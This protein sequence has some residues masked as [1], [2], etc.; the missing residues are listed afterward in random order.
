SRVDRGA[1]RGNTVSRGAPAGGQR[2]HAPCRPLR[3]RRAA[4]DAPLPER[5][6]RP[7]R[8][9]GATSRFHGGRLARAAHTA[10]PAPPPARDCPASLELPLRQRMLEVVAVNLVEN[11]I[12]YAGEGSTF[13][14]SVAK[15]DGRCALTAV[16]D[17]AGVQEAE[18]P[19]L[20]ERFY[21]ADRARAS[22]S[23]GLGLAIVKHIVG[24]AGGSVEAANAPGGGLAVRCFFP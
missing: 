20:F 24:A 7:R 8:V 14:L 17:G 21:R 15:E 10:C 16:D 11:A 18:L 12:R 6:R 9:R 2:P 1:R 5:T 23:T 4:R 13:T 22:R 19:R 3:G